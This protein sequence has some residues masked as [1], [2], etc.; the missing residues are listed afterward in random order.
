MRSEHAGAIRF[1]DIDDW[2]KRLSDRRAVRSAVDFDFFRP[3]IKERSAIR[4]GTRIAAPVVTLKIT[5]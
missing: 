2:L 5:L 1:F 3:Q 4:F